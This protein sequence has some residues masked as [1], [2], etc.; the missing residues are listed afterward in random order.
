MKYLAPTPWS[1]DEKSKHDMWTNSISIKDACG[2][3]VAHL[4]RGYEGDANGEDCP[5]YTNAKL[6]VAA[7]LMREALMLYEATYVRTQTQPTLVQEAKCMRRV[8][9]VLST[10]ENDEKVQSMN[11]DEILTRLK[12]LAAL[13]TGDPFPQWMGGEVADGQWGAALSELCREAVAEIEMLRSV[14]GA[15]SRGESFDELKG[16]AR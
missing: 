15:V 3:H 12:E 8:R 10:I 1:V 6:I 2:G 9:E 13:K 11:T 16:Q 14:S 4:T 5:S 7:P